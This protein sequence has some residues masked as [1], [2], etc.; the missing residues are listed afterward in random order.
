MGGRGG[1]GARSQHHGGQVVRGGG[2]G[3]ER[4]R[5]RVRRGQRGRVRLQ[6]GAGRPVARALLV[7]AQAGQ[8]RVGALAHLALV[9]ALA[10]VQAHVVAQRGR[11]AE[12][13]V[14]EAAHEGL[15]QRVDAHVR[16]QVAARVEAAVADDAAH[17]A[18]GAR[19]R[20]RRVEVL[21]PRG[22]VVGG[23]RRGESGLVRSRP[24]RPCSSASLDARAPLPGPS[25]PPID[26]RVGS[27]H[28]DWGRWQGD[29]EGTK[30]LCLGSGR[31]WTPGQAVR[32]RGL[33]DFASPNLNFLICK[34]GAS[35]DLT[36]L[37][38]TTGDDHKK[39]T[40]I[41]GPRC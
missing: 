7:G 18:R 13:A 21:W 17:A 19:R 35:C 33:G 10:R 27:G 5:V 9:G 16:A 1:A 31:N 22:G 40:S 25:W 3:G 8:L 6:R 28:T 30:G 15:V 24:P 26:R 4:G 36:G 39:L 12:A 14:A 29:G 41:E 2:G 23:R 32:P 11:L 34:M 38:T 37:C 20:V